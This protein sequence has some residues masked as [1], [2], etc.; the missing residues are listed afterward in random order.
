VKPGSIVAEGVSRRFRVHPQR[1]VTLKEAIVR[2]RHL[3]P[4]DIWAL[5]D[6][7]FRIEPGESVGLVGRNGSG[8]TTLLRLIA[9]IF[10]PTSG[11]VD[12]HGSIG[13]LIG[14]GAGFHPEFT[15]RENVFLNG[16]IHGLKRRYVREQMDEIVAFAELERFIDLPVRTYSAGMYIRLGFAIATHLRSDVLLLDEVFAVGDEAFQRK[17]FGKIFEFKNR[18]GTIMF[19][20]HSAASVE[21]LC[22]RSILLRAGRVELDDTTHDVLSRYQTLLAEDED[23]E[24]QSAGLQEWGSGEVRVADVKLED[25]NGASRKQFHSGESLVALLRLE[26]TEACPPPRL[27]LELHAAA[28]GLLGA[29]VQELDELGWSGDGAR[30]RWVRFELDSLP[31]TEGRFQLSVALTGPD[32]HVYHRLLKAAEFYV[33][34]EGEARGSLRLDGQWSLADE[35]TAVETL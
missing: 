18:G 7:S 25:A 30:S 1:T 6:V 33:Y 9:G 14:L 8:K 32:S 34:P 20:S 31:L 13:S 11:R 2:R 5:R 19:V 29:T 26:S 23:P 21:S 24:E 16:A 4:T 12:V 10:G 17:C 15:G 35:P 27:S 22:E 28:G 3:R